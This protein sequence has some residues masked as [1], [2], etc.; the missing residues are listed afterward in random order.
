M[1]RERDGGFELLDFL[2]HWADPNGVREEE[3]KYAL[4]RHLF[5]SPDRNHDRVL[6]LAVDLHPISQRIMIR[7]PLPT[8]TIP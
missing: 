1:L 3:M 5:K 7:P 6:R 4:G 2:V 8:F